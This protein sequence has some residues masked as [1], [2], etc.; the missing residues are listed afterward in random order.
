M[1]CCIEDTL[2][3]FVLI[4]VIVLE[5]HSLS[6]EMVPNIALTKF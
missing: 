2:S 5:R 4:I 6:I 1:Q 3:L